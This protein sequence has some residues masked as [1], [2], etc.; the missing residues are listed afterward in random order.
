VN[1]NVEPALSKFNESDYFQCWDELLD[2]IIEELPSLP[3]TKDAGVLEEFVKKMETVQKDK[4]ESITD[5]IERI[6]N[7]ATVTM[8]TYNKPT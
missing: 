8:L 4:K 3:P 1:A 5:F 6:R 7:Y 2:N